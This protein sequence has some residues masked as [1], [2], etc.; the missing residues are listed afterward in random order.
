MD[1]EDT[2]EEA[3]FRAKA[4]AF[5]DANAEPRKPGAVE[6]YRRGQDAPGAM[7]RAKDF[8]RR[9]YD[10]GF[11]GIHWPVEWGGGGGTPIQHV[12]YNQEE[13]KYDVLT[14]IFGIGIYLAQPTICTWGTSEQR[15]RFVKPAMR[16]DE[17]W[18]QLFSEPGGGSDLAALRT[19]A[20]RQG[21]DWIINGQKIWNSG[22]HYS[23]FG[24]LV[25]RSN[26]DVPKHEGLTFFILDMKT[27]GIEIRPIRQVSGSSHFNEVFFTDV[28]VP[29]SRRVGPVGAGWK[30]AL[31]TLMNERHGMRDAPGPDVAELFRLA[32]VIELEDGP[33]IDNAAVQEKLAEFYT[34]SQGLKYTKFRGITAL[35]KG[36]TPGPES[37]I[38]K[39]V[40][41]NKLLE[42]VSFGLDMIGMAGPTIGETMPLAGIFEEALL[43]SPAL[44]LAGGTD[45]IMKNIIA[46]RVLGLPQDPRADKGLP[47]RDIPTGGTRK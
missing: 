18:C 6:G 13:A 37:S 42:I 4:R 34:R 47:F 38:I 23:D 7:E 19:R 28:R 36:Q 20:E 17:V 25:A 39:V 46:E 3:A 40:A 5:L 35:S 41:A 16:A 45:E 24:I 27:P 26:P 2:P 33:A 21:E 29:D 14:A 22:A 12:I 10:A 8:Q 31:T 9:K 44:R 43:Y 11:V 30:V 32:Q 15:D 1:F